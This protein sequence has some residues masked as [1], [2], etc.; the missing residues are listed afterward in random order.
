[1]KEEVSIESLGRKDTVM[2]NILDSIFDGVYLVDKGRRIIFWNR[3]AEIITGYQ[4]EE[5]RG[6]RC[7]E[8]I[9][10]HIDENGNLLCSIS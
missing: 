1:M 9:L 8:D 6:R 10:N 3:G 2:G 4:A 7:A 5:V